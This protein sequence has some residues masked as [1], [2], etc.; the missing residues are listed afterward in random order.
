MYASCS[1]TRCEVV[2]DIP[3]RMS[4]GST[5]DISHLLCFHF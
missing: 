5:N 2:D 4:M 1:T 3:I